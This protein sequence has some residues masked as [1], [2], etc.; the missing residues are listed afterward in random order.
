[1]VQSVAQAIGIVVVFSGAHRARRT[2][3]RLRRQTSPSGNCANIRT[4]AVSVAENA[5]AGAAQKI[6]DAVC[7]TTISLRNHLARSRQG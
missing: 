7:G 6:R 4:G 3:K 1:M 2:A 5:T